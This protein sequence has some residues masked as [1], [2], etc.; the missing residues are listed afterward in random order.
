MRFTR[1]FLGTVLIL[2]LG[3]S[4]A[5]AHVTVSPRQAAAGGTQRYAIRV[6]TERAVPTVRIE[7]EI[8]ADVVVS[9]FDAKAGWQIEQKKDAAGKVIA[10]IWSG[11]SIKPRESAEFA[12][13]C[14][15][16]KGATKLVWK[17]VQIYE[18]GT[19]SEWTG[20][21]GSRSPAPVTDLR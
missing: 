10:A 9:S 1:V 13:T 19:R 20:A 21:E 17:V 8:P 16:P 7:M 12:F 14:Q 4:V 18:D 15:N 5:L 6:P 3:V 11:S 2:L